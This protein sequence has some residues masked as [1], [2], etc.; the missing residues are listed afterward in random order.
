MF[1]SQHLEGVYPVYPFREIGFQ[2]AL[3]R[4][5]TDGALRQPA[6][7]QLRFLPLQGPNEGL[8]PFLFGLNCL[9]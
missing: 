9:S 5:G 3:R 1:S 8:C 7:G 6:L 2:A 4:D